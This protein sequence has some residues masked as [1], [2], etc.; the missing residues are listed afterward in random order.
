MD[1][2]F[3]SLA[4]Y[5]TL[6]RLMRTGDRAGRPAHWLATAGLY[7]TVRTL[8]RGDRIIPLVGDFGAGHALDRLADWL[9]KRNLKLAL[10][11]VSDVEFFLFRNHRFG[12]YVE[13]LSRFPLAE[14]ALVVRSSTRE[15]RHAERVPGDSSTTIARP[16][17]S[18]LADAQNLAFRNVDDLFNE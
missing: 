5:P 16:L 13:S 18:F 17:A 6:G 10:L 9:R 8:Q 15:I 11:Y 7:Q 2:R 12:A 4:M 1:A 14:G 3:L